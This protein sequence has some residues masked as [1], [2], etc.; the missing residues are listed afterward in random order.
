[1]IVGPI[2]V[3]ARSNR[4]AGH[5]PVSIS[6]RADVLEPSVWARIQTLHQSRLSTPRV[7]GSKALQRKILFGL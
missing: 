4:V 7:L 1:M 3:A 2:L 6:G 5:V